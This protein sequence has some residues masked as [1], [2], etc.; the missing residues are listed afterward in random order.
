MTAR[1]RQASGSAAVAVPVELSVANGSTNGTDAPFRWDAWFAA[2]SPA[3]RAEAIQLAEQQGLL[4]VQQLPTVG[5]RKSAAGGEA[6]VTGVLTRI[7]AGKVDALPPLSDEPVACADAQL[8][9]LQREAVRRVLNTPDVIHLQGLPGT[10]RSRV[11]TEAIRQ[12]A[13]R[14]WRVLLLAPSASA[15]DVVLERLA[16]CAEVLPIRLLAPTE[17]SASLP[18]TLRSL[19]LAEQRRAMRERALAGAR[20]GHTL[21]EQTCQRRQRE[22]AIWSQLAP[23]GERCLG[24]AERLRG[25]EERQARVPSEVEREAAG[26]PV[27]VKGLPSGPFAAALIELHKHAAAAMAQWQDTDKRLHEQRELTE[28]ERESTVVRLAAL[29]PRC[30]ARE[31]KRWWTLAYWT[32][33]SALRE[34]E[35]LQI[36]L[37]ELESAA[38]TAEESRASQEAARRQIEDK[39]KAERQELIRGETHRRREELAGEAQAIRQE[40]GR[41]EEAWHALIDPLEPAELRPTGHRPADIEAARQ[42]WQEQ[43]RRDEEGHQFARQW[44]EYL[45]RTGEQLLPRLPALANL[46]AGPIAAWTPGRE[47]ADAAGGHFDLLIIE[48]ADGLSETELLRLAASAPR[49]VV[50]GPPVVETAPQAPVPSKGPRAGHAVP[51][52]AACWQR[53]TRTLA[54]DLGRLT[55]SWE[56]D[57]DRLVCHLTPVR[58]EDTRYLEREGLADAPE[59]ELHILNLP[60]AKPVLARV[61]FPTHY[62]IA[63]ATAF[64]FRELQELPVQPLGRT[65]WWQ[66]TPDRWIVHLGPVPAPSTECVDLGGGVQIEVIANGHPYAGRTTCLTFAKSGGWDRASAGRWLHTN[67]HWSDRERSVFLQVPYRMNRPLAAVVGPLLFAETCLSELLSLQ[68]SADAHFEF[69]PVPALRRPELPREGAGLEQDLAANRHG[70]RVPSDLRAELPRK[71]IVNYLEAQA[72]IRRLEHWAKTPAEI[73]VNGSVSA[74]VLVLALSEAQADLLRRLTA[75]SALLQSRPFRLEITV[76]GQVRHREAD[77][78]VISLTRSHS[79]RCVPLGEDIGDLP[80]AL[81]RARQRLLVFGDLGTLIRRAHWQGPLDHL[82]AA[83]A[84]LEAHR[85]GRLVRHLQSLPICKTT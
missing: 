5:H 82:S 27:G 46:L 23:L 37:H 76:P 43:R 53:L 11:V 51:P 66:D 7:L 18:P 22:E 31:Q 44:A 45:D 17:H 75:R 36:R 30:T 14:G 38:R 59:I 84:H 54:D 62:T 4:Y 9:A 79:H 6:N 56:R 1:Q 33:G 63:Q 2:A 81:T 60:R 12:A 3:Q 69:I 70:D 16:G 61:T 8:D 50:V 34:R 85:V 29:A 21:A 28:R 47:G 57:G 15:V 74:G 25:L 26:L 48:D 19:T 64:I 72:L 39:E 67:L 49:L 41:A 65:A 78:L 68:A 35:A 55:Y 71:G 77:V 13:R 32:G 24:V 58:P 80:L 20:Q 40:L 73:G 83:E 10:G 42:R 52:L